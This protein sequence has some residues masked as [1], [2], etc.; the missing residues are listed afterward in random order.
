MPQFCHEPIP[1]AQQTDADQHEGD[2][3]SEPVTD[4]IG[5]NLVLFCFKNSPLPLVRPQNS[6][7]DGTA[8]LAAQ[9]ADQMPSHKGLK[10][11]R[12]KTTKLDDAITYGEHPTRS[13]FQ[14]LSIV[15]CPLRHA[16]IIIQLL[17]IKGT[18]GRIRTIQDDGKQFQE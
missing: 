16:Q 11:P 17:R 3:Q 7:L 18:D 6:F 9:S 12:R 2:A 8:P 15:R 4:C 1:D 10:L 5:A 13:L 14:K